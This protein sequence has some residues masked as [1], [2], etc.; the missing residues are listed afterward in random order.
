MFFI[1]EGGPDVPFGGP[2]TEAI[3]RRLAE[4]IIFDA[5]NNVLLDLGVNF[6]VLFTPKIFEMKWPVFHS[7]RAPRYC[8]RGLD[9]VGPLSEHHLQRLRQVKP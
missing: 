3:E 7:S 4:G 6:G 1:S 8:R 9:C 2:G 5:V